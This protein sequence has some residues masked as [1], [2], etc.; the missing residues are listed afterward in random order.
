MSI[1][2]GFFLFSTLH[3]KCKSLEFSVGFFK[4][5]NLASAEFHIPQGVVVFNSCA[6]DECALIFPCASLEKKPGVPREGQG[7]ALS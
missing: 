2:G 4:R 3:P 1:T 5:I 7:G 6:V